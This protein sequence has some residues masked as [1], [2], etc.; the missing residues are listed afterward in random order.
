MASELVLL[1][2]RLGRVTHDNAEAR[3]VMQ[4]VPPNHALRPVP[5]RNSWPAMLSQLV[6]LDHGPRGMAHEDAVA[7]IALEN[8]GLHQGRRLILDDDSGTLA[9]LGGGRRARSNGRHL[10]G[11]LHGLRPGGSGS[12]PRTGYGCWRRSGRRSDSVQSRTRGLGPL[13]GLQHPDLRVDPALLHRCCAAALPVL[14]QAVAKDL[15]PCGPA[16][17]DAEAKVCLDG[18]G[19]QLRR[20][21]AP[22]H[23]GRH[24]VATEGVCL[25]IGAGLITQL[26]AT[27]LIPLQDISLDGPRRLL[28][29]L[30]GSHPVLRERVLRDLRTCLLAGQYGHALVLLE[31]AASDDPRGPVL[32]HHGGLLDAREGAADHRHAGSAGS[33]NAKALLRSHRAVRQAR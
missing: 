21:A 19:R 2:G 20:R 10:V 17:H 8:V 22:E 33:N 3:V 27:T 7:V 16:D 25:D 15:G 11:G 32:Q 28:A 26:D 9:P 4:L 18:V 12:L 13:G 14:A 29:E 30:D 1:K 23:H 6:L 5:Q 31:G 24:R